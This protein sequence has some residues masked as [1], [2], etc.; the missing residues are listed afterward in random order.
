MKTK[1]NLIQICLLGAALLP[2]F[3]SHAQTTVT[4]IAAGQQHGLFIK[5]DGSLWAMGYNAHGELGDGTTNSSQAPEMIEANGVTAIAARE[6]RSFFIKSGSL[7]AMGENQSGELGDGTTTDRHVPVE[8]TNDVRAIAT[9]GHHSLFIRKPTI[10][11]VQLWGMGQNSLG[12]LGVDGGVN[13]S[14]PAL[15]GSADPFFGPVVTAVAAGGYHSLFLETGGSLWV[16]GDNGMGEL[17]DGTTVNEFAP[18]MIPRPLAV[19]AVA[20]G[21]YHSLFLQS[22]GS[23]WAM[24]WNSAGQ[25]GNGGTTDQHSPVEIEPGGVTAIAAAFNQSFCLTANGGLFGWGENGAGQLGIG[26][27]IDSLAP[28]RIVAAGVTAVAPG[29]N[30]TLF[31]L[32]DGSLW[33]MGYTGVGQ[34][35]FQSAAY[36]LRPIQIIGPIVANGGFETGDLT[37]WSFAES[38]KASTANVLTDTPYVHSGT[39]GAVLTLVTLSQNLNT[40][41]GTNY[42]LS[43]WIN[44]EG[45][46][47]NE[48]TVSWN[49]LTLMDQTNLPDVGWT[50]FQFTVAGAGPGTVLQFG[51]PNSV[52]DTFALDDVSVVPQVQPGITGLSLAGTNVVLTATNGCWSGTYCILTS[53][54]MTLP[55][56]Q[57]TPVAT[58]TL[59]GSGNFTMTATNAVNPNAPQQF[60]T[61]QLQ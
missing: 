36:Q 55:L 4:Q 7:W 39:H 25:L 15:V 3:A 59:D 14:S 19:T 28:A 23:V 6:E 11:S 38:A 40:T 46:A 24:G 61:L 57:W 13:Q 58:N 10:T 43:F 35:G 50:N 42:T 52:L 17:G 12:Q 21:D 47:A 9:G 29:D 26:T 31:L 22:D 34:L 45:Y 53:T 48:F 56:S 49:G 54:N 51:F 5:S 33:G 41:P 37:D 1:Q 20:G 2:A 60:Y 30:F 16:M 8:I 27:Q 44:S 18:E 32:S